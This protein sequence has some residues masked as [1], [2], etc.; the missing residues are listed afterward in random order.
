MKPKKKAHV[1]PEN[2]YHYKLNN[3]PRKSKNSVPTYDGGR[4]TDYE[5]NKHYNPVNKPYEGPVLLKLHHN[6]GPTKNNHHGKL[7][8]KPIK[9]SRALDE[10]SGGINVFRE[11]KAK[12]DHRDKLENKPENSKGF[13]PKSLTKL[14]QINETVH[15]P[16]CKAEYSCSDCHTARICRP[17]PDGTFEHLESITCPAK[18]PNC[19]YDTGTCG[20]KASKECL[21][22]TN[23]TCMSDGHFPASNCNFYYVCKNFTAEKRQ[24]EHENQYY[25][26]DRGVCDSENSYCGVFDCYQQ[27]PGSKTPYT[28]SSKYFGYCDGKDTPTVIDR[29]P[30]GT[31]FNV[32]SQV[33]ETMC[34]KTE[35]V[36][37]DPLDCTKYYKCS[38]LWISITEWYMIKERKDCPKG[39]G[40]DKRNFMCVSL[41][42]LPSCH[43]NQ[44]QLTHLVGS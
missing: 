23:F 4:L 11:P 9:S 13:V 29:C 14:H 16:E 33:C 20:W 21:N 15:L 22:P 6:S 18:A 44:P 36:I 17:T 43:T 8:N 3:K 26:A 10:P 25:N 2:N 28:T 27:A 7:D 34:S 19:N 39:T 38:K 5:F 35:G 12:T 30:E 31:S 32:T 42:Q 41:N 37:Q 24:C 40:F 1:L